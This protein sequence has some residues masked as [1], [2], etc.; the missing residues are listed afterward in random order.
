MYSCASGYVLVGVLAFS[1]RL[2]TAGVTIITH[3][4]NADTLGWVDSMASAIQRRGTFED[5]IF[6]Q[7]HERLGESYPWALR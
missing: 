7:L 5:L 2:E 4:F 1:L 3:G 6:K